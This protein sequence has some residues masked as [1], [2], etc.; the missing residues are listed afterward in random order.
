MVKSRKSQVPRRWLLCISFRE[1]NVHILSIPSHSSAFQAS[2]TNLCLVK[3]AFAI[4]STIS[5]VTIFSRQA[6]QQVFSFLLQLPP[7]YSRPHG[8]NLTTNCVADCCLLSQ[9]SWLNPSWLLLHG[10]LFR[11]ADVALPSL[12]AAWLKLSHMAAFF[13]TDQHKRYLLSRPSW[14]TNLPNHLATFL[15]FP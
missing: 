9:T 1:T 14:Q 5:H 8:R 10:C 11:G 2:A 3:Q 12:P 4:P 7:Y 6:S 13:T 15:F